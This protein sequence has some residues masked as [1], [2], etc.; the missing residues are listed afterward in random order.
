VFLSGK[1][2]PCGISANIFLRYGS[3]KGAS[4]KFLI[5]LGSLNA[6]QSY[7]WEINIDFVST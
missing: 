7:T 5:I 1:P 2:N 6:A 4:S 3:P